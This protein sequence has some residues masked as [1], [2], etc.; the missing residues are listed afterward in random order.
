MTETR[1]GD[2]LVAR[3]LAPLDS[4][5]DFGQ[6]L[7]RTVA[8]FLAIDLRIDHTAEAL[9]V[10]RK[11]LKHRLQ[12]Y[13]EIVGIDFRRVDDLVTVWWALG[14]RGLWERPP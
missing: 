9:C 5:G 13:A 4:L 10:H 14:R 6:E 3:Y 8:C 1:V 12:R 11:T 2:A 7:A